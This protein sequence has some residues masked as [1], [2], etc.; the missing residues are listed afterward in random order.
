MVKSKTLNLYNLI[1][2]TFIEENS[3]YYDSGLAK[4]ASYNVL[5][6]F[7]MNVVML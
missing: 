4:E 2:I 3:L 5:L 7:G 6:F 1:I